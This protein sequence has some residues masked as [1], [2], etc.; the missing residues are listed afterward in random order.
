MHS[1]IQPNSYITLR[2]PSG[3]LKVLEIVPN[4]TISIGKYGSFQA[5]L[6][7]GR[8][9]NLTFEILDKS[10]EQLQSDLRIVPASE[11]N[12]DVLAEENT[13]LEAVDESVLDAGDGV[14][15]ELVGENGEVVMRTNRDT[16]D[17][18][19][20]Q[21]MTMDEIEML[22][23][24]GTGAGKD[25]IAKLLL[26]H[27]GLEQKTSF[28]LAKYTLRKTKKYMRRF[29]VL[30]LDVPLLT[31]WLMTE[32]EPQ[33]MMEMREEML[34][35]IGSWA[36]IH[37]GGANQLY[38]SEDGIGKVGGGRW[39]VVDETG[40][41]V[42]AAMAE[43]MGILYPPE[44]E[45]NDETIDSSGLLAELH[46][47]DSPVPGSAT[48]ISTDE[49]T[50]PTSRKA[51]PI[52]D[53]PV[54]MSSP[55]NTLTLLHPAAQ[56]NLSLLKYFSFTPDSPPST[57]S[58]KPLHPLHTRL[59]TLS[60]LQL[61]TP[62]LDTGYVEP[63]L[64]PEATLAT[65]KSGKRGTYYRKRRRWARI[66][67]VVDETRRGGYDGLITASY[68]EPSTI[69]QHTIP[70]LRG[71]A[72]IVIYSPTIEP[73]S[74]LADLYSTA[75]RTAFLSLSPSTQAQVSDEDFP[76][77]PTL[78]LAPTIQTAR[79][80]KWQVLPGRTHPLMTSRG[81]AEGYLF[82]GMRVIP[83]PIDE[84]G[85]LARGVWK[86]RKVGKSDGER[87]EEQEQEPE[88]GV[89]NVGVFPSS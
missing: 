67:A 60:W 70:L 23:K 79:V 64:I 4:T 76:L 29:T 72:P 45:D 65:W 39:L 83:V 51:R 54:A 3:T 49:P 8:P 33:K 12:A 69:L 26:S 10:D 73:L 24:E 32:K 43:R 74:E 20:R 11:L 21:K 15:Y 40:G 66:E 84:G 13:S 82:T 56:P 35:L 47:A 34:A 59:K 22:K 53:H 86:R 68:M 28:A 2:L 62:S 31:H 77:N 85:V 30:P 44:D 78:L 27:S 63:P 41:L 87:A 19:S 71:G 88:L 1:L 50:L 89:R 46:D 57:S 61:L 6:L 7:L 58:L 55:T 9:Y 48:N 75:R 80:R 25:L 16:I 38:T 37:Y 14:E 81:G 42:V 18:S 36:N 17:D 52:H 5:N